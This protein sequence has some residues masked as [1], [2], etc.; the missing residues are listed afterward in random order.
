MSSNMRFA[1]EECARPARTP[2][3]R[4]VPL[5]VV[6]LCA[7]GSSEPREALV[8]PA[9]TATEGSAL[10]AGGDFALLSD[11]PWLR[12]SVERSAYQSDTSSRF[13]VRVRLDNLSD[14]E[15]G[16]DLRDRER[17]L[18]PNQWGGLMQPRRL[19]IDERRAVPIDVTPEIEASLR[20]DF[21]ARAL[22]FIAA[23]GR[24]EYYVDFNAS[25][26]AEL[27][28]VDEPHLYISMAGQLF[29]TDGTR[30]RSTS[31]DDAASTER[32]ELIFAPPSRLLTIPPGA[33]VVVDD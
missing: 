32:N 13:F 19:V 21:E 11:G 17:T 33:H 15:L 9:N 23:H 20:R 24:A 12:V 27:L 16:V 4:A 25:E 3:V 30:A 2:H 7:C 5:V 1:A 10:S 14:G 31:L 28:A 29:V 22:T 6:F 18:Y 26:A 8:E